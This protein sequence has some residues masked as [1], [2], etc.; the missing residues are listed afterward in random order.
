MATIFCVLFAIS[1]SIVKLWLKKYIDKV[2]RIVSIFDINVE[3]KN[4]KASKISS[5]KK[6]NSR[7]NDIRLVISIHLNAKTNKNRIDCSNIINATVAENQKN[8]PRI[9]SYLLIGLLNIKN[10]VLPSIY[11]FFLIVSIT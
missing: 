6:V 8:L 4:T 2:T 3:K 10:I 9:N 7:E 11:L 1:S 5:L